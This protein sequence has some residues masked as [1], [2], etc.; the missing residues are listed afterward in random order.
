MY[1]RDGTHTNPRGTQD[2]TFL[3][4]GR[5]DISRIEP[6]Y[7]IWIL[8]PSLFIGLSHNYM[9]LHPLPNQQ[10][11]LRFLVEK[12]LRRNLGAKVLFTCK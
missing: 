7:K 11:D 8:R 12:V 3:W 9:T 4:N 10:K 6:S 2:V 1:P 5:E